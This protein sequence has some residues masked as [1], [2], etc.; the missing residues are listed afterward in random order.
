MERDL[1]ARARE[2]D[3]DAFSA[4]VVASINQLYGAARLILRRD[5]L[6]EDAVQEALLKAWL[7]IGGLR[8]PGRF[9][10]WLRR[11]LV[12]ACYRAARRERVR[13]IVEI[14]TIL[15]DGPATS[16][17]QRALAVRDQLERGFR[18]L[19]PDQR[20][21]LVAHYYLDL[22]DAEAADALGVPLG[23]MKSRLSRA[24][25]ALKAALDADD[26]R[27]AY[28]EVRTS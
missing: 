7:G 1:V 14:H 12:H 20:A 22:A 2:G 5:D 13:G 16:D 11:L 9:D 24:K 28:A 17:G 3:H 10:A 23:T 26:R 18:R 6:A 25:S 27:P 15:V 19:P 4:L 8:D 21:V